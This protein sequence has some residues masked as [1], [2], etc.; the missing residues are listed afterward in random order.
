MYINKKSDIIIMR[1]DNNMVDEKLLKLQHFF[2]VDFKIKKEMDDMAPPRD[3]LSAD[4]EY[5]NSV[6]DSLIYIFSELKCIT[7]DIFGFE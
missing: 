6:D 7:A 4:E 1:C 2:E 3:Y 5:L